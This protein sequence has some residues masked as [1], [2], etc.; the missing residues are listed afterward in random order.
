M[1]YLWTIL[2]EVKMTFIKTLK[3]DIIYKVEIVHADSFLNE[4]L[5]SN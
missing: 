1:N 2:L 4:L 5:I 3:G